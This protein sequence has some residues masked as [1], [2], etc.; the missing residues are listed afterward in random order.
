MDALAKAFGTRS[1]VAF[2]FVRLE[3]QIYLGQKL[4]V[5]VQVLLTPPGPS[6]A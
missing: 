2:F 4:M 1:I 3:M 6:C 5:Y